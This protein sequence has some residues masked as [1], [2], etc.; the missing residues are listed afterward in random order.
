MS[1]PTSPETFGLG[2]WDETGAFWDLAE[3]ASSED[4]PPVLTDQAR[5]ILDYMYGHGVG[6]SFPLTPNDEVDPGFYA[7]VRPEPQVKQQLWGFGV[8]DLVNPRTVL[9]GYIEQRMTIE[10]S[11]Y[12]L[13]L[14]PDERDIDYRFALVS[15]LLTDLERKYQSSPWEL[16]QEA[17]VGQRMRS[18]GGMVVS[19]ARGL[20]RR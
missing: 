6:E 1:S 5:V 16:G 11:I 17:D 15:R 14:G 2:G 3:A 18:I 4:L 19:T 10:G 20:F 9:A 13:H 8:Y 12:R 7:T